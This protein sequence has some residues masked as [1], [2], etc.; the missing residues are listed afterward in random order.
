MKHGKE[1]KSYK[2]RAPI[3]AA[4]VQHCAK[5]VSS[6]QRETCITHTTS[7]IRTFYKRAL[8]TLF[9][10]G[11]KI[12]PIRSRRSRGHA[13]QTLQQH[14]DWNLQWIRKVSKKSLPLLCTHD[15]TYESYCTVHPMFTA[16]AKCEHHELHI[17]CSR[18]ELLSRAHSWWHWSAFDEK[19]QRSRSIC[20]RIFI[21]LPEQLSGCSLV[22][23]EK[24]SAFD[25]SSKSLLTTL[26]VDEF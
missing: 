20:A 9:Q 8:Q 17:Y 1:C 13:N 14:V 16:A 10:H 23:K 4:T 22:R 24:C 5:L 11:Q 19:W 26:V 6:V 12:T 3:S 21:R 25:A 2:K 7:N 15:A 18:R